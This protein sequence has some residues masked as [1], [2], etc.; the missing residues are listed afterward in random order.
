MILYVLG[1]NGYLAHALLNIFK[2]NHVKYKI[3]SKINE[4][5]YDLPKE[6]PKNS[7]CINL[8]SVIG[9][10]CD[11]NKKKT[12]AI[13]I[14]LNKRLLDINFKKIIFTSS[15]S[16]YG[17]NLQFCKETSKVNPTNYYTETKL[18][19]E[20]ILLKNKNSC[21]LRLALCFGKSYRFSKSNF[22][23]HT[24][25]L[26]NSSKKIEIYTPL[27]YR[28]YIN[29]NEAAEYIYKICK[30]DNIKGLFNVGNS[31]LNLNKFQIL[32]LFKKINLQFNY[33]INF[34]IKD[35][36]NYK[37]NYDKIQNFIPKNKNSSLE[38][39]KLTYQKY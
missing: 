38:I 33:C 18:I 13:N 19:A 3:I 17:N 9:L 20:E 12:D 36:R 31:E 39:F 32:D 1:S 25:D 6:V 23:D 26:I 8:S 34:S 14:E 28:P 15:S 2:I 37:M 22:I 10:E 4:L 35:V 7:I 27:N 29:V 21:I 16:V 11:I 5:T 24:F 30:I